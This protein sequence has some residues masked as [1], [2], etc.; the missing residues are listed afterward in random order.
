MNVIEKFLEEFAGTFISFESR[1]A[2]SIIAPVISRNR[3]I[4]IFLLFLALKTFNLVS[5]LS[6]LSSILYGEIT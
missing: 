6:S 3:L 1:V 2:N 5:F 4:D